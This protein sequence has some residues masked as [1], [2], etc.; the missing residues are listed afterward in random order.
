MSWVEVEEVGGV[1]VAR[2]LARRILTAEAVE[3]IGD[4]LARL[5]RVPGG[6]KVVL[7]FGQV[8][9]VTTLMVGRVIHL[10][11][12][13]EAA[14]GR[15]VVCGAQPFLDKLFALLRLPEAVPVYRDEREAL[16]SF[17]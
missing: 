10:H 7:H 4:E 15:L 2:L 14:G 5:L 11:Q 3:A 1:T 16:D 6:A 13:A 8:E 9:S 17:F 12:Q